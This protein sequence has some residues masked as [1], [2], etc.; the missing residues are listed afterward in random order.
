MVYAPQTWVDGPGGGTPLSAARL[1]HMESGIEDAD[2]RLTTAE[3]DIAALEAGGAG[4]ADGSVTSAKLADGTIVNGDINAAAN[5]AVTKISIPA[6]SLTTS[7]INALA[8]Y[9]QDTVGAMFVSGTTYDD[10]AGTITL[11][12]TGGDAESI[13]DTIGAA[14]VSGT[15]GVLSVTVNDALDTITL[16]TSATANDTDANLKNRANHTGTQAQSTITNLTTDLAA[17]VSAT[18]LANTQLTRVQA[19]AISDRTTLGLPTGVFV[20]IWDAIVGDTTP[21]W[22]IDGDRLLRIA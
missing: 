15:P 20:T 3:A 18:A 5:I 1:A 8:E 21:S 16:A 2:T 12:A 6:N 10:G 4:L 22:F 17:K 9:I 7:Q 11:T 14:L 19:A 13:R